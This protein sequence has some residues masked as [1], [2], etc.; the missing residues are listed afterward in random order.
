MR[1]LLHD[2]PRV[3]VAVCGCAQWPIGFEGFGELSRKR[4]CSA[5]L[6]AALGL[7]ATFNATPAQGP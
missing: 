4:V 6:K 3:G 7:G 5:Y 1:E 2:L